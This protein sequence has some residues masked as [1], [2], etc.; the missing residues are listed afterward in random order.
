VT[1]FVFATALT[2]AM[3][4]IIYLWARN[5]VPG[6]PLT[7]GEAFIGGAFVFF[8]MLLI[9]GILPNAW[10]QWTNGP[11]KWRSD[12]LGIPAGPFNYIHI[13]FWHFHPLR[14][15][16]RYLGFIPYAK[17][18]FW[19]NGITFFGRGKVAVNFQAVGDS[20]AA[21]IYVIM[22]TAMVKGWLW[23]QKRDKAAKA[24]P[25]LTTSAYGRPL[26]R[27]G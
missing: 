19:P 14:P 13:F 3:S 26:V 9:Y 4:G 6:T 21:V 20:G 22:V 12:R 23:Y 24:T 18:A 8:Y 7:W 16:R 17:G 1:S 15:N 25:E 27:R 10:L 2:L 11:L 5:R